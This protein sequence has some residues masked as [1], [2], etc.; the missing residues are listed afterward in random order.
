ME[1]S[2]VGRRCGSCSRGRCGS[3]GRDW[4]LYIDSGHRIPTGNNVDFGRGTRF[5]SVFYCGYFVAAGDQCRYGIIAR[6][7]RSHD[8]AEIPVIATNHNLSSRWRASVLTDDR[9]MKTAGGCTARVR[10]GR[11]TCSMRESWKVY[12][13]CDGKTGA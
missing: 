7:I 5:F 9:A 2:I 11:L 1:E 3:S 6:S 13:N 10:I 4:T 8:R 12:E